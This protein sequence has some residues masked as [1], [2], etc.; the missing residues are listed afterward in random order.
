MKWIIFCCLLLVITSAGAQRTDKKLQKK[1][2]AAVKG[3]RGDIGI[4]ILNLENGKTVSINSDSIFPTAS[5]VKVPILLGVMDKVNRNQLDFHQQLVY[6]DSLLYA[7]VDIL[8]SFKDS[9]RVELSKV[10]MLML[11]MS[12]NT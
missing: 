12:D 9:E 7:G 3:F 11:T 10:V 6:R 4:Y 5:I 8:G 2:D 1:L